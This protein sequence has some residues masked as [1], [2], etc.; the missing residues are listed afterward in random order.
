MSDAAEKFAEIYKLSPPE[1]LFNEVM[2]RCYDRWRFVLSFRI[3]AKASMAA[4]AKQIEADKITYVAN[5]MNDPEFEKVFIDKAKFF[6]ANPPEKIVDDMTKQTIA[7]M[8]LMMN[9]ASVVF[10]HS[11]LDAA[12]LDFCRAAALAAPKDWEDVVGKKNVSLAD[13]KAANYEQLLEQ[14]LKDFLVQLEREGLLTKADL[15][16]SRCKPEAKW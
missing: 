4:A 8:E 6:E 12:A 1:R 9:A 11:V 15:L 10:V 13:A 2:A 14:K 16:L 7:E 5:I 3:T